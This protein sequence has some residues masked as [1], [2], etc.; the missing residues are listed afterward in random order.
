M[1]D[2]VV[3]DFGRICDAFKEMR[4]GMHNNQKYSEKLAAADML[5]EA[6]RQFAP[7]IGCIPPYLPIG[8]DP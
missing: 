1:V 7:Q 3:Q 6:I 5:Y 2:Q 8:S 4:D